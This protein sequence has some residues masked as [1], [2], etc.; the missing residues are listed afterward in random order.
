MFSNFASSFDAFEMQLR[1][2]VGA[3]D[4]VVDGLFEFSKPMETAYFWCP[5]AGADRRC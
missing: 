1:R 5:S 2:M 4:G 3:E